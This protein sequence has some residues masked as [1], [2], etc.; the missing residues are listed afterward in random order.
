MAW[1]MQSVLSHE[2]NTKSLQVDINTSKQLY[3][4]LSLQ[5]D[6]LSPVYSNESP[7]PKYGELWSSTA[8][9][10]WKNLL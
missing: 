10:Q 1:S 7:G 8:V 9:R 5:S 2:T 6:Y 4:M 3:G